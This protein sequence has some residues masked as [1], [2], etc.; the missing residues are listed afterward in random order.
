MNIMKFL[1]PAPY[2][3]FPLVETPVEDETLEEKKDIV[4][5]NNEEKLVDV[6]AP[7]EVNEEEPVK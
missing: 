3:E 4:E 1:K 5:W 7:E 6:E 2:V